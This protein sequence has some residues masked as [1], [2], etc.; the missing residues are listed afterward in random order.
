M[1]L[2]SEASPTARRESGRQGVAI[3]LTD[4]CKSFGHGNAVD[5]ISLQILD[6]EFFSILGPSGCGKTTLMR[7]IAGF[8]TPTS[9]SI[10]LDGE[11]IESKPAHKRDL[12]MVF[13]SYALFPHLSVYDNIAF[14][15]RVRKHPKKSIDHSV[16]ESLDLVHLTGMEGRKPNELSGG[17][18]QRVALARALVSRPALVLLDEPLGALDL[19]LRK[20]MQVELK[21]MQREVGITFVY[22]THDQEEALTMSD[23]IAVM[24]DGHLLQVDDPQ[25]LYDRPATRFVADFIGV[26]NLLTGRLAAQAGGP[27]I[28]PDSNIDGM[29][30][31]IR[32]ELVNVHEFDDPVVDDVVIVG[33]VTEA[34]FLGR[35]TEYRIVVPERQSALIAHVANT[36]GREH[37]F[38][39]GQKV[40]LGWAHTSVRWLRD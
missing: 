11:P 40:K 35:D 10:V 39:V 2:T 25:S 23:R 13:Q 24:N 21:R 14:E 4:V 32:P 19:K 15:L 34:I 27:S 31:S 38:S 1:T 29:F 7:M 17:Q 22:V 8:E 37:R 5:N 12:N 28:D 6:N 18:R 16:R 33:D 30:A 36:G 20:Q 3:E 9:G 26:S